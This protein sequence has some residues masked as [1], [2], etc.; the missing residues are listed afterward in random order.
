LFVNLQVSVGYDSSGEFNDSVPNYFGEEG[1]FYSTFEPVFER[2][3]KWSVTPMPSLGDDDTVSVSS[4]QLT[5]QKYS[6]VEHFYKLW[7]N[8]K[9]WRDF[10]FDD[11]YNPEDSE[12][13]EERRWMERQNE[14]IRV[15]RKNEERKKYAT[16]QS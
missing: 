13:R 9:S 2:W 16:I 5:L 8:F 7:T 14:K 6:Q 10:S 11:E 4:N 15:E 3:K 12:Y 1:K